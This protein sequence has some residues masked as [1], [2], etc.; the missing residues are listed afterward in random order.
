[1]SYSCIDKKTSLH[2]IQLNLYVDKFSSN[3]GKMFFGGT[4]RIEYGFGY[5][6]ISVACEHKRISRGTQRE[7]LRKDLKATAK[8]E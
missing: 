5:K 2:K 8:H 1:M 4:G 6:F 3:Q 7:I